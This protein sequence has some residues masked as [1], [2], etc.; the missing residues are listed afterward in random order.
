MNTSAAARAAA[1]VAARMEVD[2]VASASEYIPL[3]ERLGLRCI[4]GLTC[5]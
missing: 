4:A 3:D 1:R 2:R 5:R